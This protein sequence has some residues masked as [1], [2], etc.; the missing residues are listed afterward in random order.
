MKTEYQATIDP[1]FLEKVDRVFDASPRT[2]FNELLQNARRA[3]ASEVT[4]NMIQGDRD[5][6]G[7]VGIVF[8]DNGAGAETPEPLLRL[9]GQGWNDETESREDPAGMGFFCL[10]SFERVTVRSR[11]WFGTFTP[12][13]FR[14]QEKL[15]V[16]P[17]P[18]YPGMAISWW[19]DDVPLYSL[20]QALRYAAEYCGLQKVTWSDN[21]RD[22][23]IVPKGF[24]DNCVARRLLPDLG[25]EI[26]VGTNQENYGSPLVW[27]NFY[28]VRVT[29]GDSTGRED[30]DARYLRQL[31]GLH[32]ALR[33]DVVAAEDLQLVLPARNALKHNA[34][35]SKLLYE[36][37]RTVYE[38]VATTGAKHCWPYDVYR[39][40]WDEFGFNIGE[41]EDKLSQAGRR[42][43]GGSHLE[44]VLVHESLKD[45]L[46]F[47]DLLYQACANLKPCRKDP[48]MEGYAWYDAM[49][50][51]DSMQV[52]VN[53]EECQL[54][55]FFR[56]QYDG[57]SVE[58]PFEWAESLE[59]IF[60]LSDGSKIECEP[61]MLISG[62][63]S[64]YWDFGDV[65]GSHRIY[66]LKD[67][68][69]D[70]ELRNEAIDAVGEILFEP[71][72]SVDAATSSED[73]RAAFYADAWAAL[74]QFV[75]DDQGAA[76]TA[77]RHALDKGR[78]SYALD[79]EWVWSVYVDRERSDE[80]IVVGPHLR[81]D[82]GECRKYVTLDPV[83]SP[84][85]TRELVS[86]TPLTPARID[87]YLKA[88]YGYNSMEDLLIVSD[89]AIPEDLDAWEEAQ[90]KGGGQP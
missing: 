90:R 44:R 11:G 8:Q 47:G 57:Q 65:S 39:R 68:G 75:G 35:R 86:R 71:S 45:I 1:R 54:D 88:A 77:V 76:L 4:V 64:Q 51:V 18:E 50:C 67:V 66:L 17:S 46:G 23:V 55:K 16:F 19:W 21:D 22:S 15:E 70:L 79:R 37:E 31:R 36:C 73:Q 10:S 83:I 63:N 42:C 60:E 20:E 40:A 29:L 24:L 43:H 28:G 81:T 82:V 27:L 89:A 48:Q 3:G 5:G 85:I 69:D 33:V 9:A 84:G 6:R 2:V 38:W 34:G 61:A 53:R 12:V 52:W 41:A 14:G 7:Y 30:H 32:I 87:A 56:D 78:V 58:T 49:R 72:D 80:P 13:V 74:L 59:V 25:A 26:G 62:E